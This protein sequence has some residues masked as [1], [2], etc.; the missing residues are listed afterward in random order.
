MALIFAM[1]TGWIVVLRKFASWKHN[2]LKASYERAD[3]AF[4]KIER[5]C[6]NEEVA[7]G[8]PAAYKAQFKLMKLYEALDA[9]K[10]RWLASQKK[11]NRRQKFE[12]KLKDLR[13]RKI[14]YTFGLLDM[15]IVLKVIDVAREANRLDFSIVTD[16]IESLI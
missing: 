6:K 14:P 7:V 5:E 12:K 3:E 11:L 2:R 10:Q 16:F 4:Q 8:R 9:S 1:L 13:G 15:A